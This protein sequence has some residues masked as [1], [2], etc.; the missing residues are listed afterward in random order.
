MRLAELQRDFRAWLVSASDETAAR[1]G[2]GA[3][4]GLAVYQNNYRAQLVG[5]LESSFPQ[6]RA[7]M[8]EEAFLYAAV[9]HIDKH[10][11]HAWTLD[12]YADDF[13]ATLVELFP[14]NPDIHELA[15]I[16]SALS[17]AFVARDAQPLAAAD[18]ATIDWETA[19]LQLSPSLM[20]R[21]A[22]T[23]AADL[24]RAMRDG[25]DRPEGEMLAQAGGLIVWRRGFASYLHTVDALE[26]E[27]LMQMQENGSFNA[28]C[29]MLVERLGE[30]E[31]IAKAGAL[32]A[33][34][35][36]SEFI[37][38]VVDVQPELT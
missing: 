19:R 9:S 32:L 31:G 13:D 18:L 10:P 4:A 16:E 23:N 34:W 15:W 35:I 22:T 33:N 27:A 17:A 38:G 21:R 26:F 29:A 8:G 14:H 5:C 36:G 1:F 30:S 12:A 24:W 6:V 11:P 2:S 25:K 37:T 7:W 28:L 20:T 3:R